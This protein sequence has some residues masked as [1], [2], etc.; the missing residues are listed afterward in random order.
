MAQKRK[1]RTRREYT[2]EFKIEAVKQVVGGRRVCDVA[3]SLGVNPNVLSR[4]KRTFVEEGV[5]GFPGKG[6]LKPE[7]EE[8]RRLRRELAEAKKDNAI[9]KKAAAYFASLD[10]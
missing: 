10:R 1:K 4:W 9:L 5:V 6:R 7:D 2:R 3:E 8:I